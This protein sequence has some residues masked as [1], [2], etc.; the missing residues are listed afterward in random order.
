MWVRIPPPAPDLI[1]PA[2][3]TRD[4]WECVMEDVTRRCPRCCL[5]K[6]IEEFSRDRRR[7][8][9]YGSYCKACNNARL[10][11]ALGSEYYRRY[12]KAWELKHRYG[13][14]VGEYHEMASKQGDRCAICQQEAD[15]LVVD[16]DHATGKVR[17]LLCHKCNRLLGFVNDDPAWLRAALDYLTSHRE[18]E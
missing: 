12:R 18:D 5:V 11:P 15:P 13:L 6:Q 9:G 10:K 4:V 17:A 8:S 16:H 14:S 1:R 2:W 7:P 3:V